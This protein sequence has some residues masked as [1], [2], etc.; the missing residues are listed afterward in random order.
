MAPK[1]VIELLTDI[2]GHKGT[3]YTQEDSGAVP[4]PTHKGEDA[5]TQCF[6]IASNDIMIYV[7]LCKDVPV[8]YPLAHFFNMFH[9]APSH[10]SHSD[11]S[12]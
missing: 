7:S 10:D 3:Q 1:D 4:S 12:T 6:I 8:S 2:T 11:T 9:M 5:S